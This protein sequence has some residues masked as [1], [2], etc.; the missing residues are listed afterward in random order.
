MN[1]I[2]VIASRIPPRPL[3]AW[4]RAAQF[5]GGSQR[6]VPR[7]FGSLWLVFGVPMSSLGYFESMLEETWALGLPWDRPGGSMCGNAAP[8]AARM[9]VMESPDFLLPFGCADTER[10]VTKR[11]QGIWQVCTRSWNHQMSCFLL[12]MLI[13]K[14]L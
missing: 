3:E 11:K 4:R 6:S 7:F 2:I 9:R 5:L 1:Y 10:F 13:Q 14:G 8:A 12:V